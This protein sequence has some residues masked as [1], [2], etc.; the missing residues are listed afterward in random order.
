MHLITLAKKKLYLTLQILQTIAN[1][2][3]RKTIQK[4]EVGHKQYNK[5]TREGFS[6]K[7]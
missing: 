1:E 5:I 7:V 6:L 4:I 2:K 3:N